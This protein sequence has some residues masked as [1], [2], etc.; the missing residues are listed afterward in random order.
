[1]NRY[2]TID[3]FSKILGLSIAVVAAKYVNDWLLLRK[4]GNGAE[5]IVV[6]AVVAI[7]SELISF[8]FDSL[9]KSVQPIR[10]LFLGRMY[11][12]GTWLSIVRKEGK[13]IS[14]AITHFSSADYSLRFQ[15]VNYDRNGIAINIFRANFMKNDWPLYQFKHSA[16]SSEGTERR[17]EGYGE[18]QFTERIGPPKQYNGFFINFEEGV[19]YS[20]MGEKANNKELLK[21]LDNPAYRRDELAKFASIMDGKTEP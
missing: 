5:I 14:T 8:I 9:F 13:I 12:E 4:I 2:E 6:L 10:R 7:I 18:M 1:M 20:V 11:V 16:Q 15:G 3:K 21:K 19:R 17:S